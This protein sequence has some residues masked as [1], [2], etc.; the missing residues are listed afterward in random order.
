[1]LMVFLRSVLNNSFQYICAYKER[2]VHP[3]QGSGDS[4]IKQQTT[5]VHY[6]FYT[7]FH[8]FVIYLEYTNDVNMSSAIHE[9]CEADMV[10]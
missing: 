10:W 9:K 1:M 3:E 2:D 6:N 4:E 5:T 8:L 7:A